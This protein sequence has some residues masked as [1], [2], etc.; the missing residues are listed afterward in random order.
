MNDRIS[1]SEWTLMEL[2]WQEEPIDPMQCLP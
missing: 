2:L 1:E